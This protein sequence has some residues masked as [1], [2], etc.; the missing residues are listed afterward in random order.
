[1]CVRR[2]NSIGGTAY[3]CS[4]LIWVK[5]LGMAERNYSHKPLIT[6]AQLW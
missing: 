4:W 3:A 2:F 5:L 6:V 1:M